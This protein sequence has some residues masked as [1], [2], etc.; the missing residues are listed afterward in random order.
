[1]SDRDSQSGPGSLG[2]YWGRD[3]ASDS[4]RCHDPSQPASGT[5]RRHARSGDNSR[6]YE[7]APPVGFEPTHPAPEADALSPE[8]WGLAPAKSTS[9]RP[10]GGHETHTRR[11][12]APRSLRRR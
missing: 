11:N 6:V 12:G 10:S 4:I 2:A 8:L 7:V 3:L 5:F 9:P 1:M